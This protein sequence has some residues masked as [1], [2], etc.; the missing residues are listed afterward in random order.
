MGN[1]RAMHL[2]RFFTTEEWEAGV[3]LVRETRCLELCC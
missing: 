3:T 2:E 1:R